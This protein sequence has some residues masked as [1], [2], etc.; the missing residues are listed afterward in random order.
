MPDLPWCA[1]SPVVVVV[2]VFRRPTGS[3][4]PDLE[5]SRAARGLWIGA[6]RI[7]PSRSAG[8]FESGGRRFIGA[9]E[10]GGSPAYAEIRRDF[11]STQFRPDLVTSRFGSREALEWEIGRRRRRRRRTGDGERE[12]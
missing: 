2:F 11:G 3:E 10:L 9:S 5:S 8:Q 1:A 4:L 6:V 12:L 7:D